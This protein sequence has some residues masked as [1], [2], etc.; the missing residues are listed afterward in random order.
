M[1]YKLKSVL[2]AIFCAVIVILSP[3]DF[4]RAEEPSG[5]P[6]IDNSP[7]KIG[8]SGAL[9]GSIKE[10]G[11][12]M[13]DGIRAYFA[14][15]NASGGINGRPVQFILLDDGYDPE[16]AAA[17]VHQLIDKDHVLA[18]LGDTGTPTNLV[19]LPI[20]DKDKVIFFAPYSSSELLRK[21]PPDRY[22]FNLRASNYEE[23][24]SLIKGILSTGIK[25]DDLAIFA[26]N[27]AFGETV[28]KNTMQT[29]KEIGY[30]HPESLPYGRYERNT[31]NVAGAL[32][33]IMRDSRVNKRPF[34]VIITAGVDNSNLQFIK[35]TKESFPKTIFLMIS[36][37]LPIPLTEEAKEVLKDTTFVLNEVVPYVNSPLP[38]VKEYREDLK[39]YIPEAK[40]GFSSLEGYLVAKLF[41]MG[42]KKAADENKLNREGL[43]EVFESLHDVDLGIGV[44]ISFD[45]NHHNVPGK[46]WPVTLKNGELVPVDW[47][48]IKEQ[49]EAHK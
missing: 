15:V 27:D 14:K 11:K 3:V 32:G 29:L 8:M 5:N 18:L 49:M 19:T 46:S 37:G 22:V 4:L 7:I 6:Q 25:P 13:V 10:F 24:S 12:G 41:V 23:V 39:K 34:K 30:L 38:A 16:R 45:K 44:K 20:I 47:K 26:Q 2:L 33:S 31:N 36:T 42:L 48:D 1:I 17:N 9:S 43:V 28:Y 40:L 21:T 35:L